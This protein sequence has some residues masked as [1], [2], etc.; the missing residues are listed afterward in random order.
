M[1]QDCITAHEF[2][3]GTRIP[4]AL[5]A[6]FYKRTTATQ[7]ESFLHSNSGGSSGPPFLL[8]RFKP[9]QEEASRAGIL[10]AAIRGNI[11]KP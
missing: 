3:Y 5:R 9:R 2:R 8:P 10:H 11:S 6:C 4:L 7:V 1:L